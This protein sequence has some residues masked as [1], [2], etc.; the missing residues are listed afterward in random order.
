MADD[1]RNG[2]ELDPDAGQQFD[3]IVVGL[4]AIG[5]AALMHASRSGLRVLGIDRYDPPHH[6]GSSHAESRITRLAVGEGPQYLP[7]V[8][9]SHQ[10]W[11]ELEAET[12]EQLLHQPGGYIITPPAKTDDPR[13]GGFVD[14]TAD[15]AATA[16]IPFELRTPK[17]VQ[18]HVPRV[19]LQGDEKIGFEPTGGI[20]MCELA[21]KTQ[22]DLACVS[23]AKMVI[24]TPVVAIEPSHGGAT[25]HTARA[26]YWGQ[27]VLVATGAWFPDLA[28]LVDAQ[29]VTVTRQ[30][31]FWFHVDQPEDFA[32]E[33][34]PFILWPG[35][36]IAEYS[37]VFPMPP[38]GRPGLKLLGEQFVETTTAETVDRQVQQHE[39]DDFYSRLVAPRLTGV[40]PTIAHSA[41]CLYTST[42]DD[43][44]LI[45][46]HPDSA[47]IMLA[48]P[49]SGHGFKHSTALAEAMVGSLTG[50]AGALDLSSFMRQ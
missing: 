43:R 22:L 32:A 31:V 29:A 9:R 49:C 50:A 3:L 14:R 46:R 48:S 12:G 33:H 34:F 11:R 36:T 26:H 40:H 28:P 45:D 7:F 6:F 27:N 8:A 23:G 37:A 35:E 18:D 39:V 4:G 1:R 2:L 10:I 44:F 13:W 19:Q 17:Q 5:S 24:N 42:N 15:V 21:V 16:S 41:V 30:T 38:G 47:Q 25:V 20:V